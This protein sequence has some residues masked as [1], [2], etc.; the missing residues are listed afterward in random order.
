M[1]KK[2]SQKRTGSKKTTSKTLSAEQILKLYGE[3][4]SINKDI[5]ASAMRRAV[6]AILMFAKIRQVGK[7]KHAVEVAKISCKQV[8]YGSNKEEKEFV[9]VMID[10]TNL[11]AAALQVCEMSDKRLHISMMWPL[12]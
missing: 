10:D 3:G 5:L 1:P 2:A 9:C 4:A 8:D 12:K 7:G 6:K 11:V